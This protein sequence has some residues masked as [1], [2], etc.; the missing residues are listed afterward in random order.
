MTAKVDP[1]KKEVVSLEIHLEDSSKN[2]LEQV[3]KA[4]LEMRSIP[5]L[6]RLLVS[7]ADFDT[8]RTSLISE[9]Q[10][11]YGTEA[12]VRVSSDTFCI[13]ILS[14]SSQQCPPPAVLVATHV[15]M[16]RHLA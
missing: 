11:K 5:L 7:W 4:A 6:F 9:C 8:K 10:T 13:R 1:V 16:E 3:K 12:V 14:S 15:D 2:E